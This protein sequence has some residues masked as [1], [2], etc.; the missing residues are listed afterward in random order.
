MG[1]STRV[2]SQG[3]EWA[4]LG[5][6]AEQGQLQALQGRPAGALTLR[7][8]PVTRSAAGSAASSAAVASSRGS[9]ERVMV[10]Q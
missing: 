2:E 4:R 9:R 5:Q 1:P 10:R 6:R 7:L 3:R 8:P